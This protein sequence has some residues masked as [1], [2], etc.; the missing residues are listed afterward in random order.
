M[1]LKSYHKYL[2]SSS[3]LNFNYANYMDFNPNDNQFN[4]QAYYYYSTKDHSGLIINY[5]FQYLNFI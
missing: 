2:F 3:F 4:H 1:T 5:H